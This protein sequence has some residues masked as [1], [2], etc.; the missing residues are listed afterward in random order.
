M[1]DWGRLSDK[2]RR[3][4][5]RSAEPDSDGEVGEGGIVVGRTEWDMKDAQGDPS[6]LGCAPPSTAE[7]AMSGW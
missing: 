3:F 7:G 2:R 1:G 4:S 5:D 6:A